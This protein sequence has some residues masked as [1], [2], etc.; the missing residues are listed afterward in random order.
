[1]ELTGSGSSSEMSSAMVSTLPAQ[2]STT[3]SYH[4]HYSPD[5]DNISDDEKTVAPS[6][7]AQNDAS[8]QLKLAYTIASQCSEKI[9]D[10][11]EKRQ[12]LNTFFRSFESP[13]RNDET[14]R[15]LLIE[16]MLP[17]GSSSGEDSKQRDSGELSMSK[18]LHE[19][20]DVLLSRT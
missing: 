17:G 5:S 6:S 20:L 14:S 1:M 11:S 19:E 10:M 2:V 18:L 15:N 3:V 4:T 12:F 7:E 9:S 8:T 16:S 13:L